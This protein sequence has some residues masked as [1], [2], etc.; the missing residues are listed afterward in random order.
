MPAGPADQ[1]LWGAAAETERGIF[2]CINASDAMVTDVSSVV[3]DYLFSQKPFAMIAVPS[4]PEAFVAEFPVARASYVVRG[5][6]ADLDERL[7][8]MLGLTRSR[9]S[10][11][12]IR[13]DYLGDFPAEGY[14]S[15]FVDAVG[16][17]T[18]K[19][20]EDMSEDREDRGR[21]HRRRR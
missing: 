8:Q 20:M 3:S 19:S 1:H 15:A 12:R 13:V 14:A 6:L 4:E 10:G 17:V 16:H 9:R 21:G 5:D 2:D 11:R 7:D 18:G